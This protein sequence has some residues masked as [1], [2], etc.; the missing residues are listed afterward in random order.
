MTKTIVHHVIGIGGST[1]IVF[2]TEAHYWQF[3]LISNGGTVF[4]ER[5]LYYTLEAALTGRIGVDCI[6]NLE[7]VASTEDVSFNSPAFLALEP[8]LPEPGYFTYSE[9]YIMLNLYSFYSIEI[10]IK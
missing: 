10:S 2:H 6:E 8:E 7:L 3:R 1:L 5:K 9:I 4:G